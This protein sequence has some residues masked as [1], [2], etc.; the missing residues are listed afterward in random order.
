MAMA[1]T[2]STLE[3]LYGANVLEAFV[4]CYSNT[5]AAKIDAS[6]MM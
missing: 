1:S 5:S 2:L 3:V 4:F 6:R